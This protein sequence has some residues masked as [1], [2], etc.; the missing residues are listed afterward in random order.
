MSI[1][2]DSYKQPDQSLFCIQFLYQPVVVI[3][4]L[5]DGI[6]FVVVAPSA[7]HRQAEERGGG[8]VDRVLKPSIKVVGG[9]VR[10]VVPSAGP[11]HAGG[12]D[13]LFRAIRQLVTG[14]LFG[15]EAG[16]G[17]VVIQRVDYPVTVTPYVRF[18]FVPLVAVGLRK[19]DEIE[20]VTSPAFALTRGRQQAV[21][22]SRPSI[23]GDVLQESIQVVQ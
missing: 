13:S 6:E 15:D 4:L 21:D 16:V 2:S 23:G 10:F 5:L 7:L 12:D 8:C 17:H 9:I 11:N 18:E 14:Q 19:S 1:Q 22:Q 20:P 3:F